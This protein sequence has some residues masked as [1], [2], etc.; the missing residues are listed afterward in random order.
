MTDAEL[1]EDL[2]SL[3]EAA[4]LVVQR[5]P[6][7]HAIE[8]GPPVASATARV[9]GELRIVL[10]GGDSLDERIDLVARALAEH[11]AQWLE[12]RHVSPALR[13][14]IEAAGEA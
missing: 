11:R 12:S 3:A 8:G 13:Q 9:R 10:V 6:R 5:V 1:L 14:R 7:G 4:G 2:V